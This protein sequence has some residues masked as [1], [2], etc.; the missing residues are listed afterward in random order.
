MNFRIL[1]WNVNSIRARLEHI[2]KVSNEFFPD[3]ICLQETKVTN[4]DFPTE[5]I[6]EMGF[7]YIY[8]N[9]I[10]SYNGVCVLSK[11]EASE[12]EII[13]WCGKK[14]GRHIQAK[15]NG[16][17]VHSIYIPAGG[18]IPDSIQNLKF[19]HKIKFLEELNEWSRKEVK[20]NS[21]LC[22]DLNIAPFIDDVWSHERL[23]NV[24]SHTKIERDKLIKIQQSGN[25]FDTKSL[26]KAEENLFTWWS[27]RSPDFRK[28]NKG[29]R[30]DHIWI[31]HD[32]IKSIKI[33]KILKITREWDRPSD[34]VPIYIDIKS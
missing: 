30:L 33:M 29:R 34:H 31:S 24:V 8:L 3:I 26:I 10:K 7:N 27:Y 9:G 1:S 6:K 20:N 32:L 25:W 5:Q 18:D 16:I 12:V 21:I 11:I 13:N 14:D 28:N 2:K 23:K 19:E 22:G 4:Q 17:T 15:I